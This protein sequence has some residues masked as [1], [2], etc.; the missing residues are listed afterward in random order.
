MGK[1]NKEAGISRR[2]KPGWVGFNKLSYILKLKTFP[3]D[4]K[5]KIFDSCI[6]PVLV[7]GTETMAFRCKAMKKLQTTL[8]S[9]ERRML[10]ISL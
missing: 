9:M 10:R 4:L 1:E 5:S 2:V 8:R 3:I 6:L 7:Y